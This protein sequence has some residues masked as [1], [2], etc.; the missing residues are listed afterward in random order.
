MLLMMPFPAEDNPFR[1]AH[2]DETESKTEQDKNDQTDHTQK[3]LVD[4]SSDD[5]D[6]DVIGSIIMNRENHRSS[7]YRNSAKRLCLPHMLSFCYLG[8]LWMKEPVFL[9]D[10][11]R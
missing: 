6:D 8:L 1:G 7:R 4:V 3:N 5:D 2:V 10:L 9:S 11:L